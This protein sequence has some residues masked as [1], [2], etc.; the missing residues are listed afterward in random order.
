MLL[1]RHLSLFQILLPDQNQAQDQLSMLG[2]DALAEEQRLEQEREK[3]PAAV[4]AWC[5]F[6]VNN[7]HSSAS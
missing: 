1:V 7:R 4:S 6:C 5:M 2:A 3:E